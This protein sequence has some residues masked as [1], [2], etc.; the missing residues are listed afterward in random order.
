LDIPMAP[1]IHPKRG[2][3]NE[4]I[5]PAIAKPLVDV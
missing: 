3:K 1:N 2:I 5:N 4:H